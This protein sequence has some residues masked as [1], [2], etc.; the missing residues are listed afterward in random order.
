M[1]TPIENL[2]ADL[3]RDLHLEHLEPREQVEIIQFLQANIIERVTI[4]SLKSLAPADKEEFFAIGE[5]GNRAE[6]QEFLES[7]IPHF[8]A[9]A[10]QVAE[11]V[12]R[13]FKEAM[14]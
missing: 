11:D 14:V 1:A 8:G 6:I 5:K 7:K 2:S 9:L 4:E 3:L 13:E 12:V 10:R